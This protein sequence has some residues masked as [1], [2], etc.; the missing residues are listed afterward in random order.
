MHILEYRVRL[1]GAVARGRCTVC[2]RRYTYL[3]TYIYTHMY[4]YIWSGYSMLI[5]TYVH[6]Y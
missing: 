4:L 2:R 6:V 3:Y 1:L 5:Y